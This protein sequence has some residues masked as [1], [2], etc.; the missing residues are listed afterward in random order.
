F[1]KEQTLN[2][3]MDALRTVQFEL[4][5]ERLI[6]AIKRRKELETKYSAWK[7]CFQKQ[8]KV[9]TVDS[10]SDKQSRNYWTGMWTYP[11][12]SIQELGIT[13]SVI[14][15]LWQQFQDDGHVS[16]S[17]STGRPEIQRRMRTG[18]WQLLPKTDGAQHQTYPTSALFS[19]RYNSLEADR[20]QTLRA[21]WSICRRPF[22][23]CSSTYCNSLLPAN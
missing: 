9:E 17:H 12:G 1:C 7:L 20:V 4:P 22:Q 6:N 15:R 10:R 18:I 11:A 8:S 3:L 23:M 13:Q 2:L 21:H 19:Y 5:E 14:S 16:R